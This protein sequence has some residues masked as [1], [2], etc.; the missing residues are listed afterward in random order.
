MRAGSKVLSADEEVTVQSIQEHPEDRHEIVLVG[1][2]HAQ[3][4]V[5]KE[6]LIPVRIAGKDMVRKAA[7]RLALNDLVL[8]NNEPSPVKKI[9]EVG[10]KTKLFAVRFENPNT[11]VKAYDLSSPIQAYGNPNIED[12]ARKMAWEESWDLLSEDHLRQAAPAS[13][14]D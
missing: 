10:L 11:R 4:R 9:K 2:R 7:W 3:I 1:T 5:S 13:Y 6:H 14:Q 12:P 8:V